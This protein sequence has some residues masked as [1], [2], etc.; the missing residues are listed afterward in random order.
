MASA[1]YPRHLGTVSCTQ[2]KPSPGINYILNGESSYK[3]QFSPGLGL[4]NQHLKKTNTWNLKQVY[5]S[6]YHRK[7]IWVRKEEQRFTKGS[8]TFEQNSWGGKKKKHA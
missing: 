4:E 1:R 2:A 7:P 3:T 8:Q 5:M 6:W